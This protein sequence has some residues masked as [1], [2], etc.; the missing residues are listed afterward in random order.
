MEKLDGKVET[1]I[2][3]V[4]IADTMGGLRIAHVVQV[5]TCS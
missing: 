1:G 2:D 5:S 4:D 3:I